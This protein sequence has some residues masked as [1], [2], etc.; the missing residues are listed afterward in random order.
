MS[1]DEHFNNRLKGRLPWHSKRQ[2]YRDCEHSFGK[3][4]GKIDGKFEYWE[5]TG[6]ALEDFDDFSQIIKKKLDTACP[7][8]PDGNIIHYRPYMVGRSKETASPMVLFTHLG[9]QARMDAESTI[10]RSRILD[11]YPGYKTGNRNEGPEG[12]IYLTH[13][14][15]SR[16]RDGDETSCLFQPLSSNVATP[17]TIYIDTAWGRRKATGNI[18]CNGGNI[19][20]L[21]VSHVFGRIPEH[22]EEEEEE[23]EDGRLRIWPDDYEGDEEEYRTYVSPRSFGRLRHRAEFHRD[24]SFDPPYEPTIRIDTTGFTHITIDAYARS[25]VQYWEIA[26]TQRSRPRVYAHHNTRTRSPSPPIGS[27]AIHHHSRR[28]LRHLG[29]RSWKGRES[30]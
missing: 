25:P 9:A 10:I 1:Y 20:C 16:L 15:I 6:P 29:T 28:D 19:F 3:S 13:F 24:S 26:H 22:I 8:Y 23:E 14:P 12:A 21:T 30:D 27:A 7:T 17:M 2:R 18:L 4:Y 5:A 11:K